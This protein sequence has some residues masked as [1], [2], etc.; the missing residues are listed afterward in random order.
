MPNRKTNRV[1]RATALLFG[2]GRDDRMFL[3]YLV[4][5]YAAGQDLR[6][7]K[8]STKK[9]RGGSADGVVQD[10]HKLPGSYSR[11]LVKL[12][13]DRPQEEIDEATRIAQRHKIQIVFSMPCIEGTLL[14]ILEPGTNYAN[15][16]SQT[17]KRTFESRYISTANRGKMSEYVRW[18]T[19]DLLDEARQRVPELNE[20]ITY[21]ESC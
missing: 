15:K 12:D 18:F 7:P 19:K 4:S 2:E 8:I 5:I 6:R 10:A 3:A 11:K 16:S 21:I 17:C 13:K 20:L 14:N 1:V 9:G